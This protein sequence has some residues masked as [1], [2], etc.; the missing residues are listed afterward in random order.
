M[1]RRPAGTSLSYALPVVQRRNAGTL[2]L[3]RFSFDRPGRAGLGCKIGPLRLIRQGIGPSLRFAPLW[4]SPILL[5]GLIGLGLVMA[6]ALV[7]LPFRNPAILLA[8]IATAAGLRELVRAKW[9][10]GLGEY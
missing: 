4:R 2:P 3:S 10:E 7:D 6:H 5:F 1:G 8:W 9:F